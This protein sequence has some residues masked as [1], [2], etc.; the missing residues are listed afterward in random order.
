MVRHNLLSGVTLDTRLT[1]SPDI[2]QARKGVAHR[3]GM[4]GPLLNRE[5]D[6]S[7]RKGVLLYKQQI[8]SIMDYACPA[9]RSA[10]RTPVRKLQVLQSKCLCLAIG[11]LWNVSNRHIQEDLGVPL[12][13]D[14]IRALFESF[15]SNLADVRNLLVWQHGRYVRLPRVETVA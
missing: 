4:L 6:I 11:D 7:V 2:H 15:D 3:M 5:S 8:R 9:S 14:H 13:V 1:W 10:A 12:F